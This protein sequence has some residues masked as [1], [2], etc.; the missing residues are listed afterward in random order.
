MSCRLLALSFVSGL[1]LAACSEPQPRVVDQPAVPPAAMAGELLAEVRAA[2]ED[3]GDVI[4]V[5]PLRETSVREF[6]QEAVQAEAASDY[7]TAARA[8][9]QAL[10]LSADDPELLQHSAEMQLA[11]GAF[12]EA[13]RLAARSFEKG[14][15]LGGLCRRNWATVRLARHAVGDDL[16]ADRAAQQLTQCVIAPPV[17]M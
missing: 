6:V 12:D 2:G 1:L 14:P 17:R 13:E 11:L 8:L 3:A 9:Q 5:A 7:R 4:E 15:R 10:T 16:G